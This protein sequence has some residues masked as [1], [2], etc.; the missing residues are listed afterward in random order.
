MPMAPNE[1]DAAT[2]ERAAARSRAPALSVVVLCYRA[3]EGAREFVR[4]VR[5]A[6][7]GAGIDD[8]ELVL[9]A[10]Y[11]PGSGD[12]TPGVAAELA[13]AGPRT[14][15]STLEKRGM[16]GWDMKTGLAL[17]SGGV[18]A[19]IDGDGQV[20]AGDLVGAYRMIAAGGYD[21]VKAARVE[22]GDG[23]SRRLVSALYNG[24]FR[25]LFPGFP[26]RDV[27]GKPKLLTRAAYE[28]LSL[29]SD[30]WFIDAEIM[31][32]ARRLG[33]RVG[34]VETVFLPLADRRSFVHVQ[35]I[36]EFLVNLVRYRLREPRRRGRG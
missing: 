22:R 27:N 11:V 10:N 9:V 16:M 2:P 7:G 28:R 35:A 1:P 5:E 36:L 32:Q 8:Y 14:V 23:L 21:L 4:Q 26:V 13:R 19:V 34:E 3:G 15:A 18:L 31:I 29:A 24:V 33:L 25:L 6:L 12:P 17:A 30:D 20:A